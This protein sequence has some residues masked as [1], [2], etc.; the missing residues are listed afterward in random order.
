MTIARSNTHRFSTLDSIRGLML[1]WVI[2]DHLSLNYGHIKFGVPFPQNSVFMWMSF[3]MAPFFLISGFM[4]NMKRTFKDFFIHKFK[5]LIIPY[6]F[7]SLLGLLIWMI[8][9]EVVG[10]GLTL[11]ALY[12]LLISSLQTATLPSNT[13]CWFFF[14]LF[15]VNI[16]YYVALSCV[17]VLKINNLLGGGILIF[18]FF[19]LAYL[20]HNRS[21]LF[22]DGNIGLGLLYFHSGYL[23]RKYYESISKWI[24]LIISVAGYIL[25]GLFIPEQ[26]SF[27]LNLLVQGNYLLNFLFCICAFLIMFIILNK[28]PQHIL[29]KTYINFIGYNSLLLFAYHRILLNWIYE[30]ILMKLIPDCS[31]LLFLGLGFIT[32]LLGY[33]LLL[34]IFK[35]YCPVL[36]GQ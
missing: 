18:L 30:P 13:P 31:Y 26:L 33:H 6:L 32:I 34:I 8:Y 16:I 1:L 25:I 24:L 27:V 28:I 19:I 7:F 4:F 14:S 11:G 36:I 35:K 29:S 23:I 15:W 22:G 12:Y 17:K 20:S 9:K 5:K 2:V 10:G 3:F 21:Q